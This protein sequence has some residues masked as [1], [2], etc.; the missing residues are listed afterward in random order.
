MSSRATAAS[1]L[2]LARDER[3]LGIT[4]GFDMRDIGL[5]GGR[6]EASDASAAHTASR[7]LREETGVLVAPETLQVLV[8]KEWHQTFWAPEVT[9]WPPV[10]ASRPF[11]GFVGLWPPEAFVSPECRHGEPTGELF[12]QLGLL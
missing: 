6:A 4:R 11:E 5:P 10:L 1:V 12:R 7:E 2:V 8:V 3:I 9:S